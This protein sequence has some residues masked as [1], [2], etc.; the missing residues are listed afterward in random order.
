MSTKKQPSPPASDN[1]FYDTLIS[2]TVTEL[3]RIRADPTC[4]IS[5]LESQLGF[6]RDN[7]LHRPNQTPIETYEGQ[8]AFKEAIAFLKKQRPLQTLTFDENLSKSACDLVSDLGPKGLLSHETSD[9]KNLSDRIEK[10]SEWEKSCGETID[11]GSKTGVDV[12]VNIL[13]DDGVEKRIHRQHMFR[14]DYS[15]FG[16]SAGAHKQYG[17]IVVIDFTGGLRPKGKP[18]FDKSTYKYEYPEDLSSKKKNV[19]PKSNYQLQDE[20]AP[21]GTVEIKMKNE[22]R[23]WDGKRNKVTKKFYCLDN[24]TTHIIE[25]EDL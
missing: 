10:Y 9:G 2:S 14:D 24:G 7:I 23:I 22:I 12:V 6:F 19:K 8:A 15:Y 17:S 18:F 16:V 11:I 13:V 1:F 3:N 4:Y 5:I 21:D 25:M 20:D